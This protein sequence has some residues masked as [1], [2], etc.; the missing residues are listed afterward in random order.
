MRVVTMPSRRR[1]LVL[2]GTVLAGLATARRGGAHAGARTHP[3]AIKAFR[4][5]PEDLTIQAGDTVAWTNGDSAP[6]TATA[7]DG[8]WDTGRLDRGAAAA[9][10]FDT[11]GTY[12]YCCVFHPMMTATVTVAARESA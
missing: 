7:R 11:P 8:A 12:A 3:V 9:V 2:A 1:L 6:H 5:A 10:T 4:F